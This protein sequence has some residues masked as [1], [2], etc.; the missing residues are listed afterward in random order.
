MNI[1]QTPAFLR[2]YH[3]LPHRLLNRAVAGLLTASRPAFAVQAAIRYWIH[4]AQI[5]MT[6]F[7]DVPYRTVEDFFLR[8]LKTGTRPL[9]EGVVS[10][11]D[12]E[13]F[14]EGTISESATLRVKGQELSLSRLLNGR[15]HQASLSSLIG[16]RYLAIFLRPRGYHYIHLP[17]PGRLLRCQW[18]PGRFFPQNEVALSHIPRV[19]ERNERA[20]LFWQTD[21]SLGALPFAMVL[22]GA[23]L[24]GGIHL[25]GLAQPQ[26][27]TP[28]ATLWQRD[29]AKGE[30]L[31]HF[32]FGST[33]VLLLPRPLA[34]PCL[35]QVGQMVAQGQPLVP[36]P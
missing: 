9:G 23:S 7:A 31:G 20:A 33:V 11:V 5:D 29:Y 32:S 21:S 10:P 24:V 22:V 30:R 34:A 8:E 14:A 6:D 28:E 27:Q 15:H 26:W 12:G 19:Y 4:S 35:V 36:L 13:L 2:R 18:I 1:H 25:A 16:G 17:L 3:L